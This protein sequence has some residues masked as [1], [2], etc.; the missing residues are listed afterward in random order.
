MSQDQ[1]VPMILNPSELAHLQ[2]AGREVN[3][4][5]FTVPTPVEFSA[6]AVMMQAPPV[7][8]LFESA[9]SRG[10]SGDRADLGATDEM[11]TW[12]VQKDEE[13]KEYENASVLNI[14]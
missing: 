7:D 14:T 1:L 8:S 13:A 9:G 5:S 12:S 10:S 11:N 4:F 3:E 6:P 2:I